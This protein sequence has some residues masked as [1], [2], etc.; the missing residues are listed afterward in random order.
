MSTIRLL[1]P[2]GRRRCAQGFAYSSSWLGQSQVL[3]S[4]YHS[5]HNP[6]PNSGQAPFFG[7]LFLAA[8]SIRRWGSPI[9]CIGR[10]KVP[11]GEAEVAVDHAGLIP[12]HRV[13][14][15]F[16]LPT[17]RRGWDGK[18]VSGWRVAWTKSRFL[19]EVALGDHEPLR[20][21]AL[22]RGELSAKARW[23]ILQSLRQGEARQ[24]FEGG[25]DQLNATDL[26]QANGYIFGALEASLDQPTI[27]FLGLT[28][29]RWLRV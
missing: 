26:R 8:L 9:E 11:E 7:G 27:H 3:T 2:E 14:C 23:R 1:R 13:G 25:L 24:E 18:Q 22:R 29:R 21:G 20:K 17:H 28:F 4:L 15:R 19:G 6:C 10:Y 12:Q 16:G 5:L